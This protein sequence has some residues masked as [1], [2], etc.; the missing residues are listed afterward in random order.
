[1]TTFYLS[2]TETDHAHWW[3]RFLKPGFRHVFSVMELAPGIVLGINPRVAGL[4]I[5]LQE[6]SPR[7]YVR[8]T[9]LRYDSDFE[10]RRLPSWPVMTCATVIAYHI[11]APIRVFTPWQ[12]FKAL[13]SRGARVVQ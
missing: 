13:R 6:G 12:L 3:N 11:G 4:E 1:M 9:V 8:G 2:F 10:G 5:A 7:D